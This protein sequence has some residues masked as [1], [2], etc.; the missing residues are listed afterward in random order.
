MVRTIL[1]GKTVVQVN[2]V[3]L[4]G[5]EDLKVPKAHLGNTADEWEVKLN[6]FSPTSAIM[7]ANDFPAGGGLRPPHGVIEEQISYHGYFAEQTDIDWDDVYNSINDPY[8]VE[9]KV[10][11]HRTPRLPISSI[12]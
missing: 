11:N 6:D 12:R 8:Y 9:S 2:A 7:N 1:D 10:S 5:R 4:D 3:S